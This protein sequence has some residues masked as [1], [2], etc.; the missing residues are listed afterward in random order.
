MWVLESP[1]KKS[2]SKTMTRRELPFEQVVLVLQGGGALGAYQGGVYEVLADQNLQPDWVTGISIGAIN[3]ALI[4]GNPPET[5]VQKVRA[6]WETVTKDHPWSGIGASFAPFGPWTNAARSFANQLSA[7][8]ALFAGVPGMLSPRWQFPWL[9]PAGNWE[10]YDTKPMKLT[11]ERLVDFDRINAGEMRFSVGAVNVRTGRLVYFEPQTH[12]IRAEHIMASAALPPGLPAVEID[13]EQ[14]WDGG[15]VSNSPLQWVVRYGPRLSTLAFQVDLWS[16]F[17]AYPRN[18]AEAMTRHKEIQYAS[19]TLANADRFIE[20][21][22]LR[23]VLQSFLR[24]LPHEWKANQE[25]EILGRAADRKI[26]SLVQFDYQSKP[27]EGAS[28]DYEF[29]RASMNE[30]WQSGCDDA[31]RTLAR[32]EV[33]QVP[34]NLEGITFHSALHANTHGTATEKDHAA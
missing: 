19:R 33:L 10:P 21:Q 20:E 30:H 3:A 31:V 32:P 9:Y 2:S 11:L 22:K 12:K 16:G 24:K 17:G 34:N 15:I 7:N 6:F 23:G 29:S 4:A 5:R 13:G 18:I 1:N 28:K 25:A 27:Y 26:Y 14:Y 8:T